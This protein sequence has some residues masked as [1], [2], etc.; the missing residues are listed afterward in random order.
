MKSTDL[1]I[2]GAG[3][4]GLS[5][6]HHYQGKKLIL[7]AE[8]EPGGKC[9]SITRGQSTFD[10]TGHLLHL[11]RPEMIQLV[12]KLLPGKLRTIARQAAIF[13]EGKFLHF[14]FQAN[15]YPLNP[16][17]VKE[18]L[19]GF[20]KAW[21]KGGAKE[22]PDSFMQ[23]A[24]ETFGEGICRHFIFPYNE[25]LY[26]TPVEQM[27]ADWVG[28][29]IPQPDI[30]AV[31]DGAL[32]TVQ[33]GMGYNAHF[34]Y[35]H[36]GG[37]DIL[38]RELARSAGEIIYGEK[39]VEIHPDRKIA[40]TASGEEYQFQKLV[41]TM[42]L[43]QLFDSIITKDKGKI[44][45]WRKNLKW[46]NVLNINFTLDHKPDWPWQWLYLAEDDF[47]C[48]RVGVSSNISSHLAP[49]GCCSVYAEVS[50]LPDQKP[51]EAR[52]RLEIIDDLKSI[53]LLNKESEILEEIPLDLEYAY[54]IH[55]KYRYEHLPL[56]FKWLGEH[57]LV[58]TGRWG[59]WEYGGMEDALWQGYQTATAL[60]K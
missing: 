35:P 17:T 18:C 2:I 58:S 50:W 28:W 19:L 9:R 43:P 39:V 12:E 51:D 23:W 53:G 57:G 16:Q 41:N 55:D 38:P 52:T 44:Q 45:E 24:L 11:R 59:A 60:L 40:V 47:R 34:N 32:G 46:V 30:E 31:I 5:T 33:E 6:A 29:S 7:E 4:A 3:L 25:K 15:F 8:S 27:S 13:A 26:R 48:Y 14:P 21:K 37:I 42:P 22:F 20:V 36:E 49:E 10:Y 1:L 56:M 54:V